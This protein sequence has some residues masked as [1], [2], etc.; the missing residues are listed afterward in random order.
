MTNRL[1][2]SILNETSLIVCKLVCCFKDNY[3][4]FHE[5][6]KKLIRSGL[7]WNKVK[8]KIENNLVK[9]FF[10]CLSLPGNF[11]YLAPR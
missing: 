10:L 1:T 9:A 6:K 2:S 5:E 7:E 8:L 11:V 3:R 4:S